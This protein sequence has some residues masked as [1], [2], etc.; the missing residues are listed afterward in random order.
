MTPA[1]AASIYAVCAACPIAMQIALA[2]GAPLGRF[3]NGGLHPG[4]LPPLWRALAVMQGALMAAMAGVVLA[5]GGVISAQ[6][7][8]AVFWAVVG[9]SVLT[10]IA[11]NISRSRPERLLWGPVTIAMVA[12]ALCVAFL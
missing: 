6:V 9:L 10:M 5:Q 7:A 4:T 11:N 3:A 8:P 2:F 12:A 1:L